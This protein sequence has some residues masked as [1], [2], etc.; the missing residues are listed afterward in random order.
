M[1]FVVNL[2]WT[3]YSVKAK[4]SSKGGAR[5][6]ADRTRNMMQI[7]SKSTIDDQRSSELL[8][9]AGS[10]GGNFTR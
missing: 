4:Q 5:V 1:A 7:V 8:A 3:T 10:Q 2:P 9:N 6:V